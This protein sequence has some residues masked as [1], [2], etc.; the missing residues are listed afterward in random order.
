MYEFSVFK[1]VKPIMKSGDRESYIQINNIEYR[2]TVNLDKISF[3][4]QPVVIGNN[5]GIV[6]AVKK[7]TTGTFDNYKPFISCDCPTGNVWYE[8]FSGECLRGIV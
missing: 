5:C 2:A 8:D 1:A 3:A 7:D 6:Y 4:K